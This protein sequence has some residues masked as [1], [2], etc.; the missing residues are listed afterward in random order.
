MCDPNVEDNYGETLINYAIKTEKLMSLNL[1]ISNGV[2]IS[3]ENSQ[4]ITPLGQAF[5]SRNA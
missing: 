1:L 3:K 2:D 5:L 4:H